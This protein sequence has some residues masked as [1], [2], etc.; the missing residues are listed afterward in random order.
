[1]TL[2]LFTFVKQLILESIFIINCNYS[3][4]FRAILLILEKVVLK[5]DEELSYK[6]T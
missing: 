5:N 3:E 4:N 1:M 2:Y 6:R